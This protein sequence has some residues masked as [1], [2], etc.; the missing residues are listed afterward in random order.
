MIRIFLNYLLPFLLPFLA[1]GLYVLMSRHARELTSWPLFTLTLSGLLL[2]AGS[3]VFWAL[4]DGS[5]PGGTYVPPA[6]EDGEIVPGRFEG[7]DGTADE[8]TSG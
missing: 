5:E 6:Y 8:P 2:S 4:V 3:L 1:Y 7:N